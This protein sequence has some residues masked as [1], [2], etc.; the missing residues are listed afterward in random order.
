MLKERKEFYIK[1]IKESF[2]LNEVCKKAGIVSTTGNY[3]TLKKII[4]EEN[5]DISHF[6]RIGGNCSCKKRTEEYLINGSNITSYKLKNK[7]IKEGYKEQRCE[8][9]NRTEWMGKPINV[10]LHHINGNNRD[11][12]LENLLILCPNC[13]SYTENYSGKNQKMNIKPK[14]EKIEK[15]QEIK[16]KKSEKIPSYDIKEMIILVKK[17]QNFS[18]IGKILG[19]S[20]RAVS[21]RFKINKM[22]FKIKDLIKYIK[23][24]NL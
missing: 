7:L 1:L 11:N 12:R 20:D 19:I 14:Q 6:K 16:H 22:P 5:I 2:S 9:C 3:N 21:K 8:C 17:H 13:H 24:N 23:D 10:E 4:M 18:K 15:K